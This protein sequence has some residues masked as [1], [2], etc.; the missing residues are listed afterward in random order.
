MRL[1]MYF[2]CHVSGKYVPESAVLEM[3]ANFKLPEDND[4]LFDSI[5]Y[6]ELQKREIQA[7]LERYVYRI[8]NIN[9]AALLYY[10]V[11]CTCVHLF[12]S[13]FTNALHVYP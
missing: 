7:L 5:E 6:V 10:G 2:M 9:K 4:P 12:F 11:H 3:K 8:N 1:Y 13:P